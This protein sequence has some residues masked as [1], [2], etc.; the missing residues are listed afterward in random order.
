MTVDIG[1]GRRVLLIRSSLQ[2]KKKAVTIQLMKTHTS[3]TPLLLRVARTYTSP[4]VKGRPGGVIHED[5]NDVL[6]MANHEIVLNSYER[7]ANI[8]DKEIENNRHSI[9]DALK[10][11]SRVLPPLFLFWVAFLPFDRGA[12]TAPQRSR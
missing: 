5:R 10:L 6:C 2:V 8:V 4:Y 7:R 1:T 11:L 3:P 9:H 12:G